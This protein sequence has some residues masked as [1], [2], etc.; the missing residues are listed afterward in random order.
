MLRWRLI[1]GAGLVA[2]LAALCWLDVRADRP[3]AYLAP[4]AVAAAWLAAGEMLRLFRAGNS[5]PAD[6]TVY[7]GVLLPVLASAAAVLWHDRPAGIPIGR[8]G[9]LALGLTAGLAAALIGEMRRYDAPGRSVAA[10]AQAALAVL[11]VG[12]LLGMLVQLRLVPGWD[13]AWPL[14]PLASMIGV[15]KLSDTCQY[16]AGRTLGKHKLA[17]RI[18]PG[19]TWEGAIYGILLATAIGTMV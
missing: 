12:G 5:A 19:K 2:A 11:Y 18:S 15:V 6:W 17:P 7:A 8:L 3:G 13:A 10:A 9:W 1:V 14:L 16:I 4:L